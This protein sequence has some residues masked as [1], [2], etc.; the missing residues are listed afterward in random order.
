MIAA[1][2]ASDYV[3]RLLYVPGRG[4]GWHMWSGHAWVR[5]DQSATTQA[6]LAALQ[7]ISTD[8]DATPDHRAAA[9]RSGNTTELVAVLRIASS[10]PALAGT[11]ADLDVPEPPPCPPA[12]GR[13]SLAYRGALRTGRHELARLDPHTPPQPKETRADA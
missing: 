5:D 10:L 2:L 13:W 8:P 6:F 12:D 4:R 11:T 3:G 9:R 7:A 1:R